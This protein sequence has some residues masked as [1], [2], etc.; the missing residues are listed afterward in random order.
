MA[1]HLIISG[2]VQGIGYRQF[3]K[4]LAKNLDLLGWVCN[5]QDGNV[6][7][8][9]QTKKQD[10]SKEKIEQAIDRC[11]EGPFLAK[12]KD[13]KTDWVED[14]NDIEDFKIVI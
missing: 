14:R 5:A 10:Q 8:F 13:I 4:Q 6:E 2:F 7:V 12:V 1:A 9:L 3:V 11:W